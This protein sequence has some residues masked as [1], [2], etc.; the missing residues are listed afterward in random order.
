MI[1]V[2]QIRVL[3]KPDGGWRVIRR[4][5][6]P[7]R[8]LKS[9]WKASREVRRRLSIRFRDG[10]FGALTGAGWPPE[11]FPQELRPEPDGCRWVL[12]IPEASGML[13]EKLAGFVTMEGAGKTLD[14]S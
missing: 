4:V 12:R 8:W 3:R 1:S 9:L 6:G 2:D 10:F 14:V 13:R 5:F 11:D 7:S